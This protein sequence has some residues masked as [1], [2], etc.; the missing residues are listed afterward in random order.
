LLNKVIA[1]LAALSMAMVPLPAHAHAQLVA[2]N[3]K[4]S[5]TLYK[6]PTAIMLTFDDDLISLKGSNVIQVLDPKSK[7]IQ[8]GKTAAEGA[9]L[10]IK[11]KNS[12][13]IGRYK[14][15]WR[16]LSADGHPVSGAYY[17]YLAKRK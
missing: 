5:A 4:V 12:S 10:A 13:L 17:Y 3:P 15:M 6:S 2:S 1:A 16:A 8:L 14:V 7:Q 9:T 11:L